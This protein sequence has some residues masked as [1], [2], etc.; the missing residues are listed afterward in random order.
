MDVDHSSGEHS[1]EK[2]LTTLEPVLKAIVEHSPFA[3]TYSVGK[4][5]AQADD[6]EGPEYVVD[7]SG[8][9]ADLLLEKNATLLRALEYVV[10]KA[11]RLDEEHFRRIA[12]DCHD[13]RRTRRDELRLMARV[14]AERVIETGAPFTL[15]PMNPAERRIIHIA[16]KDQPRIRTESEGFGPERCVVI[17]PAP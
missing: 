6:P 4:A 12:F 16:L 13:W 10:L 14:A 17:S 3:L 1:I 15:N 8:P 7:F 2:Y 9:D 11:I 5:A